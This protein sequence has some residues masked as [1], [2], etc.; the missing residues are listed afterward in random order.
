MEEPLLVTDVS[1]SPFNVRFSDSRR[2][3]PP[4]SLR[5]SGGRANV[6][7]MIATSFEALLT[8][9]YPSIE[10]SALSR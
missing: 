7:E 1:L 8:D 5:F 4:G 3:A 6:G 9:W 10:K 2:H